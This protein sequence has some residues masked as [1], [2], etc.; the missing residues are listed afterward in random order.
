[1]LPAYDIGRPSLG[2]DVSAAE[3]FPDHADAH[4]L[5][6]AEKHDSHE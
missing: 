1:M 4:E 6:T 2:L 5:E 3:I